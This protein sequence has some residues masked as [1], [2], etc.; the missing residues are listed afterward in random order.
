M[1][2]EAKQVLE[3]VLRRNDTIIRTQEIEEDPKHKEES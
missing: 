2:Q 3:D 1:I